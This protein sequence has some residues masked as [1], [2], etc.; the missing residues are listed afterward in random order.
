LGEAIIATIT[1]IDFSKPHK[2]VRA[3][4][5]AEA[6]AYS[7]YLLREGSLYMR[8]GNSELYD[9]KYGALLDGCPILQKVNKKQNRHL[10]CIYS[11]FEETE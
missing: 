4:D 2:R 11:R 6:N 7:G 8:A 5:M 3:A 10:N 1:D 9:A